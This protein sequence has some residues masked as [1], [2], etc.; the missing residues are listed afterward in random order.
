[1]RMNLDPSF[2]SWD[3]AMIATMVRSWHD[4][5]ARDAVLPPTVDVQDLLPV[6]TKAIVA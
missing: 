4:Y 3:M 5:V 1:M 2:V 6:S